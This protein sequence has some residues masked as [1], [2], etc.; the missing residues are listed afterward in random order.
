MIASFMF[1][2]NNS[3]TISNSFLEI[4]QNQR[5]PCST[6][7]QSRH[8]LNSIYGRIFY[9]IMWNRIIEAYKKEMFRKND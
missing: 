2:K 9:K 4:D 8:Y 7:S 3:I 5:K 6:M 1:I